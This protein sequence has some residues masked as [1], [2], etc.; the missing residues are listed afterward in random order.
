[1][2][3]S[4]TLNRYLAISYV[5]NF[6][7]MLGILLG[8]IFMFDELDL[9]RRATKVHDFPLRLVVEMGILKLPDVGQMILPFAILFSAMFTFWRLNRRSELVI[10]RSAG[11]SVWQF[12]AP[13]FC[14]AALIGVVYLAVVNPIGAA[15]LSRYDR[16]ENK[17]ILHRDNSVALLKE[18]LWLLQDQPVDKDGKEMGYVILHANKVDMHGWLLHDV[19]VLYIGT[20]NKFQRRIDAPVAQLTQK[21]WIFHNAI[22]NQQGQLQQPLPLATLATDLT[23]DQIQQ[24][25]SQPAAV[26][27]WRM[28]A[29]IQTMEQ[30]GFDPSGLKV[31]FNVLL[32][33]PLMFAAMILLAAAVSLKPPRFR[34]AFVMAL[35]GVVCGFAL[36]FASTFLQALGTSHQIPVFAASWVPPLVATLIGVAVILNNEDG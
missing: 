13:I 30:T 27:F 1:M 7:F 31:H 34:G 8:I 22:I 25:F 2:T 35:I 6:L 5:L 36:F 10:I 11:F 33:Q 28:P 4:G 24:S 3:L 23:S 18:G 19:M 12:L 21:Q 9:L 29:F 20:D 16:L 15:M 32:A 26:S 14:T 17:L